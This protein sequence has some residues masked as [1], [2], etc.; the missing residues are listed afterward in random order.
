VSN[1]TNIR[2]F[3]RDIS[4]FAKE[5][6][7]AVEKVVIKLALDIH[8]K[9]SRRTPVD[10]GRARASWDIKEGSPSSFVP[11]EGSYGAPRPQDGGNLTGTDLVFV[12]SAIHYMQ[13]LNQGS[14]KQAPAQFIEIV[15]AEVQVE[16]DAIVASIASNS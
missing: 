13:F 14:S 11:P 5:I 7:V 8:T 10:T 9:F 1:L 4:G 6:N 16:F 15:I 12:T 2:R 3:E